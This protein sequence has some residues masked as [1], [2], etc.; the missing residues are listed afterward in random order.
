MTTDD[1]LEAL[2][3]CRCPVAEAVLQ[4][5]FGIK[6]D[7][8]KRAKELS[9]AL[10]AMRLQGLVELKMDGAEKKWKYIKPKPAEV[11]KPAQKELF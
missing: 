7:Q 4:I 2:S 1:I 10:E 5:E 8:P 6:K 9:D 3:V 11:E